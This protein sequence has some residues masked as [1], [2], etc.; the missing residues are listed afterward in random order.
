VSTTNARAPKYREVPPPYTRRQRV[1]IL[2]FSCLGTFLDGMSFAIFLFFL[3]PI[4]AYFHTSLVNIG[5]IQALSYIAGILGGFLFGVLSDR[6]GRRIGL[7][8]SIALFSGATL[9][10]GI[11]PNF[12]ILLVLRIVAGI[13]IGGESGVAFAYLMESLDKNAKRGA[14]SGALQ[15]M[16][17]VGGL[18]STFLFV[19]TSTHFGADAWRWAFIILGS[20]GVISLIM[21]LFMPESRTWL[22]ARNAQL[23]TRTRAEP[24]GT[25]MK[26]L[27][28]VRM[29]QT[30][31]LM[32]FAFFGAYA[33]S[34]YSTAF[35]Q[36]TLHLDPA[37]VGN[38]NY[39]GQVLALIAW[40]GGGLLSDRMGRR[41][42]FSLLTVVGTVFYVYFAAVNIVSGNALTGGITLLISGLIPL[43]AASGYFGVQGAWLS[44]LFPT[45]IRSTA[46]NL[47]YYIGRG[48]GAGVMPFLGLLL[49]T[50]LGL[51]VGFAL[52]LGIIGTIGALIVA[53]TLPETKG[54]ELTSA[55]E[56][57]AS[58][59]G[60]ELH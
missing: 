39:L 17:V 50:Q 57:V 33:F 2:I 43:F 53:R 1:M 11:A 41:G 3:A 59:A 49:A 55:A 23:E 22:E 58:I 34:T 51:G 37:S 9:L 52:G 30:I 4:A 21:R 14:A 12:E 47:S 46:Q 15:A 48:L 8:A 16:I 5:L 35:M 26:R 31:L 36:T 24:L 29:L 18:A 60:E 44:E 42:A 28:S 45:E 27:V 54:K 56:P 25:T 20:V 19:Q 32:T 38:L 6:R 13:G 40:F 10:S 7:I